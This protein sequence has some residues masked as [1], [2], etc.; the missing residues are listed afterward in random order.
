[1][2]VLNAGTDTTKYMWRSEVNFQDFYCAAGPQVVSQSSYLH[3]P[4]RFG[5]GIT[6]VHHPIGFSDV[7]SGDQALGHQ[8]YTELILPT[9]PSYQPKILFFFL[10][11][12]FV[13]LCL[14]FNPPYT[15]AQVGLKLT[16]ILLPSPLKHWI[17][18]PPPALC[19]F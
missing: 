9:E 17:R 16:V 15:V 8:A 6:G 4:S 14:V 7:N 10:L 12:W 2:Y 18:A 3:C 1:M 19:Y 5:A 11:F 13:V